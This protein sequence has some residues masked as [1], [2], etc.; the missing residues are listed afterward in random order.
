MPFKLTGIFFVFLFVVVACDEV[1][2]EPE[3]GPEFA[4]VAIE[5][6]GK[7]DIENPRLYRFAFKVTHPQGTGVINSVTMNIL[8]DS[9]TSTVL[10]AIM[11][12]D[13]GAVNPNSGDIVARDGIYTV[14]ISSDSMVFAGGRF[15]AGATANADDSEMQSEFIAFVAERNIAPR[16]A[17]FNAPDTLYS[18]ANFPAVTA[19]VID[20]NGLGDVASV[21]L[22][23]LQGANIVGEFPLVTSS[24]TSGIIGQYQLSID[25]SFAAERIGDYL[26]QIHV[27]DLSGAQDLSSQE[28]IFI[29]NEIPTVSNPAL[30]DTLQ[31]PAA[32]SD[33][34]HV[35]LS[36]D[37]P[38]GLPDI[39]EVSFTVTLIGGNTSSPI[40]MFDDGNPDPTNSDN[41]DLIAGDGRFSQVIS[42]NSTN[43]LGT[44][45]FEFSATDKVSQISTVVSD[46]LEV[47]P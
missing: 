12:D 20:S 33:T 32:G 19:S 43:Q 25:S 24:D 40:S 46:T 17:G 8:N 2:V 10:S 22:R 29:E 47:V 42:I 1:V 7:I 28:P 21:N 45:V 6:P 18:G 3:A 36:V 37:D 15:F 16:I 44:Y 26:L 30:R 23:L 35:K 39:S 31:R 27:V 13:G 5:I 11:F 9:Q 34:I 41:G 14:Q 4:V 38:Q